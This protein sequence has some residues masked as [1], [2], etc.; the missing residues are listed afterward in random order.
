MP[1][2][3]HGNNARALSQYKD[4]LSTYEDHDRLICT[5]GIPLLVKLFFILRRP[6]MLCASA[7]NNPP[8]AQISFG[9]YKNPGYLR[10]RKSIKVSFPCDMGFSS[11]RLFVPRLGWGTLSRRTWM[12]NS[13]DVESNTEPLISQYS[14]RVDSVKLLI[15]VPKNV[16]MLFS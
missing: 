12:W 10:G 15:I 6:P 2:S 11:A 1:C 14:Y 7:Q 13:K 9:L 4:G 5:M 3:C 16:L 8:N